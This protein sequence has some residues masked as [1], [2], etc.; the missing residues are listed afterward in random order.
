MRLGKS[1]EDADQTTGMSLGDRPS[2]RGSGTSDHGCVFFVDV[3]FFDGVLVDFLALG[4]LRAAFFFVPPP[5]AARSASNCK[6][7][8][9]V[10]SS[11]VAPFGNDAFVTPSVTYS[12]YRP[13]SS[14]TGCL[15]R[16]SFRRFATLQQHRVGFR[17]SSVLPGA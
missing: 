12:P 6:A 15:S 14:L 7:T 11:A 17:V 1:F 16:V 13:L 2:Q 10:S 5:A 4:V 8:G 9:N 3:D